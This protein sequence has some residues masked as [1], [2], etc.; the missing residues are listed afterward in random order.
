M[1]LHFGVLTVLTT[2]ALDEFQ[3][4][5]PRG[6]RCHEICVVPGRDECR[7]R[8]NEAV[9][10]TADILEDEVTARFSQTVTL[11]PDEV[12]RDKASGRIQALVPPCAATRMPGVDGLRLRRVLPTKQYIRSNPVPFIPLAGVVLHNGSAG[13]L[14][15]SVSAA[16]SIKPGAP[17]PP[18][19]PV[20]VDLPAG[21]PGPSSCPAAS[22]T[23]PTRSPRACPRRLRHP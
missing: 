3:A 19:S 12:G 1:R 9:M 18:P 7:G 13:A 11:P 16:G 23:S 4:R 10:A 2:T 22:P 5:P 14:T 6:R 17:E 8:R 21:A 20:T 15:M